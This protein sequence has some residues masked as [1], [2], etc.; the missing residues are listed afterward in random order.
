VSIKHKRS[1]ATLLA[2]LLGIVV[3]F[4]MTAPA[5]YAG[6]DDY[7]SQWK[8]VAQDS[9]FDTWG[10]Y[11]RECVSF[12]AWRLH[13]RN[14][15][16]MPHAIGNADAWGTWASNHGY[17]VNSTPAVG[18]VAWWS[19][20][21]VAW[22]ESAGGGNVTVEEYNRTYTGQY[23]Q[24]VIAASNPTG[25]IHFKD[26]PQGPQPG[27]GSP[28]VGNYV[29]YTSAK[30]DSGDSLQKNRYIVSDNGYYALIMQNDGNLVMYGPGSLLV[31][32]SQ[33]AAA[34]GHHATMMA[35]GD[36][37]VFDA[38]Q[39]LVWHSGTQWAGASHLTVGDDGNLAVVRN[40][41]SQVV[42]ENGPVNIATP[43]YIGTDTLHTNNQM[44]AGQFMRSADHRYFL[45]VQGNG[46]LVMY[47]PM[48]HVLWDSGYSGGSNASL[49]MQA[50]GN[51]VLYIGGGGG[52]AWK[53]D[54]GN[55]GPAQ[56][57]IQND[58]KFVVY[59]NGG[60]IAW[61]S[62]PGGQI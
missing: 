56:V 41:D 5:A 15:F 36:L 26:I 9:V 18:A 48:Y 7:P 37:V 44:V 34:G 2:V 6:T 52:V 55:I 32:T 17:T 45:S 47:G 25:Y 42:W 19:S 3:F 53:S 35:G 11:N 4:G 49:V 50:D 33:T 1:S 51:L 13:D 21:H 46:H 57:K 39:N 61:Q 23:S 29:Y 58:G 16:E 31:W 54:T 14:G 40:S 27:D 8:N 59:A 30:L 28:G 20:G 62:G 24:R 10:Y 43:S 38:N 60:S 22:V 12:V